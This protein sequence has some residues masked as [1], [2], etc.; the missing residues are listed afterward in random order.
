[1]NEI[2][3]HTSRLLWPSKKT[4]LLLILLGRLGISSVNPQ[5]LNSRA[6]SIELKRRVI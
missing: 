1:M 3:T 6:V 4:L 2:H 5:Q